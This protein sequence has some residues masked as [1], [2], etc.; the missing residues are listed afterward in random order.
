MTNPR[1]L[2]LI[3]AHPD[4]ESLGNGGVIA[5]YAA[6]GIETYLVTAT[7][8]E[9][10]WFGAEDENPG[11]DAL[12]RIREKELRAAAKVL[13]LKEVSLLDYRD[14]ELNQADP[15][16][17]IAKIVAHV[18]RVQPD[19][20]VT[21]DQN[22]LYGHPDHIAICQ[23]ATAAV[24]AAADPHFDGARELPAH[25]VSKLYYMAWTEED[26]AG[27]QAAFGDLV[28]QINGHERRSVA[29]QDWAI[30]T[31]I[32]TSEHW[33]QVWDAISCHRTQLPGYQ[34]LLDLPE[35]DHKKMWGGQVYYRAFSVVSGGAKV[36]DSLFD[37]LGE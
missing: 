36:E 30:T 26:I 31:K 6:E 16:E 32:D 12:G 37:G 35:E 10:G 1:K 14:G 19:V 23:F 8:G 2:M 29:W 13:G 34:K 21:F 5:R 4:D 7:R 18:R 24:A 3:L 9:S 28:M 15:A 25:H 33:R 20:V 11:P 17:I 22:G 27:Y